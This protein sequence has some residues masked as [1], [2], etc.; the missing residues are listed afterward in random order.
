VVCETVHGCLQPV[1][2]TA[3]HHQGHR[4]HGHAH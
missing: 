4:H 2:E 3:E 1:E